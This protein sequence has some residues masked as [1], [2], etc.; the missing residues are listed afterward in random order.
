M[1]LVVRLVQPL[2]RRARRQQLGVRADGDD[3][4]AVQHDDAVGDL[5]RVAAGA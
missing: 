5:Q 1:P 2:V 3:A 4:A